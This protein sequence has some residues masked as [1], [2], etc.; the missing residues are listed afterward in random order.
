M[1]ESLGIFQRWFWISGLLF[2]VYAA[3]LIFKVRRRAMW[4]R[5]TGA[6]AE[7]WKRFGA[8]RPVADFI[9][10]F[11]ESKLST[12]CL[13]IVTVLFALLMVLNAG[14]YLHFKAKLSPNQEPA[15]KDSHNPGPH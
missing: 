11:G 12:V 2:L 3:L 1:S 13:G 5:Y 15:R 6:E 9:R 8:P 14:A 10:R 7:F 4:L